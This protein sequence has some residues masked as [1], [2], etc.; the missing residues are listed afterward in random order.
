[1]RTLQLK[2]LPDKQKLFVAT[3]S[4]NESHLHDTCKTFKC[5]T[6]AEYILTFIGWSILHNQT[7]AKST[8][9]FVLDEFDT[10]CHSN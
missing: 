4:T 8:Y 9:R 10:K 1:M 2:R 6:N 7:D 5:D 3:Y